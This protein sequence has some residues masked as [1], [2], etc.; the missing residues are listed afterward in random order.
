MIKVR[1]MK[2]AWLKADEIF[3]T[4]Y[5]KDDESSERAGYPIYRST[6]EGHFNDYICDLNDRLE[7]NIAEGNQ[8]INIWI[9]PRRTGRGRRSYGYCEKRRNKN[10]LNICRI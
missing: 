10:L 6:A 8:S 3:P 5:M 4:D 1:T 2:E 7:V 9:D